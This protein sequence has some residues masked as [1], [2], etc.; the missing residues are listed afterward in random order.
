MVIV[1][2]LLN[3]RIYLDHSC[4][5]Y[6]IIFIE[7][8]SRLENEFKYGLSIVFSTDFIFLYTIKKNINHFII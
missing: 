2:I 3:S 8:T 7:S 6:E 1:V 5:E 4:Y